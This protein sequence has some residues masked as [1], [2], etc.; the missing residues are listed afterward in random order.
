MA[1]SNWNKKNPGSTSSSREE[2][3]MRGS[4]DGSDNQ[5][6]GFETDN[7][8][9]GGTTGTPGRSSSSDGMTGSSGTSGS[10][11]LGDKTSSGQSANPDGVEGTSTRDGREDPDRV[12]QR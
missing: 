2:S 10:S 5:G 6:D 1:N 4:P 3:G 8:R 9:Q 7:A 11:G 12:S